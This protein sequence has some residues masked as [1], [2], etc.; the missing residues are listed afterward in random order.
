M[1][2][3]IKFFNVI[4]YMFVQ[5]L[6]CLLADVYFG[7]HMP[8]VPDGSMVFFPCQDNV[9]CCGLTGIVSFKKKNK[10]DGRIDITSLKD[11]LKKGQDL[12]YA[13]CRQNDLNL[14]EHYLG[15]E[16]QID[17][18]FQK[19]RN[20]KCNDLFYNL[21]INQESQVELVRFADHLSE[22]IDSESKLLTD[23]ME[24]LESDDVEILFRRI[25]DM[26]DIAWCLTSEIA[27]NIEKVK[28]LIRY[29][30]ETPNIYVVNIFK[31]VN[32]ILNSIGRLEVRGRDSAGISMM[33]VFDGS[34]F[35]RFEET[36]KKE[37]LDDQLKE[38]SAHDVLVNLGISVNESEDKNG[39]KLIAVAIT[40]KVAAEVGSLGDNVHFLRKQIKNDKILHRLVSFRPKYH[41]I[42]A[43]TRWASVGAINE[44]NCHPV[45][46]NTAGG[47]VPKS[48]IIHACLNGDIDNYM[49]LKKEYERHGCFIHQDITTDTKIIPL[50]IEKYL[51]QGFDIQEAFRLAANDFKGSHA[52]SMHTDLAP[53]KLFLAQKGGGQAIFIGIAKDYYMPTSEVY[54]LIEETPFFIKMDGEKGVEGKDGIT[55]GQIFILNQDSSG[56]MDGIK[57][58][59]YDNTPIVLS[60]N[61]IKHTEITSRDIDRKDFPHYFLKEISESP[62]S[63]EKTI[64]N[65]WKIKG[66]EIQQYEIVLDEKTFPETLQKALLDKKIRRIF[67]VGQG[68]AG[69]AAHACADILNYYI[70]DFSFYINA[71]KASELSGFQLNDDDDKKM[72]ADSLV[73]AISQSGTT[74]DTNRTVDMVKERGAHTMAI[75]NRRDSDITFKVDGVMYTS[76]GRDIEM[77]VAST[78]AFYSQIVAGALLGLKIAG[79][80]N[81]RS[82]DF[83]AAQIKELLAM[84]GNMKKVLSMHNKIGDS[85]KRLATTKTYWAA[86]GSGPNKVSADEIRIKLS[87]LCYKTISSDFVEDKK[88]IDLSSEPLIIVCAAGARSTVIG[89]IIKDTAIFQAHNATVVVIANEGEDRF[90]PYA[91]DVFHVPIV[92]EHF[93]PILNTLVG[94]IWGYYAAMAINEGSRFLYGFNKDIRETVDDYA[95]KGMDVYEL[96]LEKSFREKIAFFYKEFRRKKT[97]NSFPSAMGL[98]AA[99]DLTLLLKYLSGRLPVS[100]F[101]IDFGKK[102]TA[103]NMLNTLFECLGESINC[104]SRPVDAIRHQAKTVTVGTSRISD[105]V[106][107]VLFKTLSAYNIHISQLINRNIMVLKNLQG[108]VS[109]IKGAIFYKI[110]GLNVLGEPTDQTTIKII[111][112]DGT[113]KPIPS[114]VETDSLLKGTK[115][116]I[117]REGNVYI[118]KGRKDD[119]SIIVI[120]II[121]AS[122]ATP[123]L[124]EYILLLNISFKENVPLDVKIKALG[125]KYERI[126]NIVQENSVVWDES[127]IERV[128]MK[129][130]FGI[131][132]EKIGEFIVSRVS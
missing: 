30:H 54:G 116:I 43:H 87:E 27:D 19:V 35:E 128:E 28:H 9:L 23:H 105:K 55:R 113:L 79:L 91:A 69:V 77:S 83:I 130:L 80:L 57:A 20:L 73:I 104:M 51:N 65:R 17:A 63:V 10:P 102:G 16:N 129:E 97:A 21:L 44:P 3:L 95:N 94:H 112:K 31:Q 71:I 82:D 120:P 72:M 81:R 92:S 123:N 14:K 70:D 68:T 4:K 59:Y 26:K 67:F 66:D 18:L 22:F 99:S 98:E 56:G 60:K 8:G 41:T 74:T 15:G 108:I 107:G 78:K 40:Y 109:D 11:M 115:R 50:Q 32:A 2:C 88:H 1:N 117:V 46:N 7:K 47:I 62:Y 38:R 52:I 103:L 6:G 132:A 13:D 125:G 24:R 96:I 33:F 84:P 25:D 48:G 12:C 61:D 122:P 53:G 5:I 121:S 29:K 85:A 126:K 86:V 58:T 93:A 49:E 76:S 101:E 119:R 34:E 124:I 39:Q 36:L 64:Q 110:G 75:V 90:E 89:D 37:N 42:S 131:S 118:G 106:E 127:Y 45:D 100:D 111:K 114:R